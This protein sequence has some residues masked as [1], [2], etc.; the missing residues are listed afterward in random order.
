[1]MAPL[2]RRRRY[3]A[4]HVH[5]R[6][7]CLPPAVFCRAMTSLE[8]SRESEGLEEWLETGVGNTCEAPDQARADANACLTTK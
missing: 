6:W 7:F 3:R 4:P 5:A 8:P 1:M 2:P